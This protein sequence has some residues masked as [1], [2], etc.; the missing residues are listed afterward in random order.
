MP[1]VQYQHIGHNPRFGEIAIWTYDDR[2]VLHEQ[3]RE[4]TGGAPPPADWL[5]WSHERIFVE[6]K[7]KAVG[8]V[9]LD[10]RAGSIYIS[11]P[12]VGLSTGHLS[13]LLDVLD[14]KYP[15]TQWFLFGSGYSGESV[16]TALA[17]KVLG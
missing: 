17:R 16:M 15:R 2:G 6:I 3:R 4:G 12:K 11:D 14:A 1:G 9:E 8:R 7:M 10:R 5:D 13:R